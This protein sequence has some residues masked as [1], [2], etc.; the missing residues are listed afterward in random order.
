MI[1][2]SNTTAL[3]LCFGCLLFTFQSIAQTFNNFDY[4]CLDI[5]LVF[6]APNQ[7]T[8]HINCDD[9]IKT[10]DTLDN[11][12]YDFYEEDNNILK[13]WYYAE[14]GADD[15]IQFYFDSLRLRNDSE[16]DVET[17]KYFELYR[18]GF[19]Y[20]FFQ[21][22]TVQKLSL[23]VRNVSGGGINFGTELNIGTEYYPGF[24]EL[25]DQ[26][27]EGLNIDYTDE[28][29][30]LEGNLERL[31]IGGDHLYISNLLINDFPTATTVLEQPNLQ[32]YPNPVTNEINI[33]GEGL[34]GSD[35]QIVDVN[36]RVVF[37]EIANS[38]KWQGNIS[39]LTTG[40]FWIQILNEHQKIWS[41]VITKH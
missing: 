12:C 25:S 28:V 20:S 30:T 35:I 36:G 17:A 16:F 22:G 32:L 21:P 38:E 5:P 11:P 7:G 19:W 1:T 33:T 29:L 6:F 13:A 14:P 23:R 37:R 18:S 4:E 10:V 9:G 41:T 2:R 40:V 15:N 27:F 39:S 31:F 26:N 24:E 34:T 3:L 8:L